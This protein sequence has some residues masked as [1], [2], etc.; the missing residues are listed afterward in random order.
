SGLIYVAE[1]VSAAKRA[2]SRVLIIIVCEGFGTVKPRLG[3]L[4]TIGF[5][6]FIVAFIDGVYTKSLKG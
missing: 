1:I 4:L 3:H 2:L 5:V 6:Y